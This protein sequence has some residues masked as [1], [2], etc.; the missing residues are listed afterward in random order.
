MRSQLG[1]QIESHFTSVK[2]YQVKHYL[3]GLCID[4]PR[5]LFNAQYCEQCV[6]KARDRLRLHRWR[7]KMAQ[8]HP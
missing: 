6:K 4:C 1:E 5:P 2:I 3:D 8:L 7:R